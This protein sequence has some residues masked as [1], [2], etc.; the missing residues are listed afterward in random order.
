[1]GRQS[2]LANEIDEMTD[3][4]MCQQASDTAILSEAKGPSWQLMK[5]EKGSCQWANEEP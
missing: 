3:C 2:S 4:S 1:M 5:E